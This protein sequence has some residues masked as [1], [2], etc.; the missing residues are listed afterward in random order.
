MRGCHLPTFI[1]L[2]DFIDHF[3]G[4]DWVPFLTDSTTGAHKGCYERD[5]NIYIYG[6]TTGIS[7]KWERI[8]K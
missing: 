8:L 5:Y 2:Y 7:Y 6:N 3:G 1:T 4:Y